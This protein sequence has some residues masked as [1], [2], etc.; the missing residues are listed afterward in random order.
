M[1]PVVAE[2]Q[3]IGQT[4]SD[5]V[6]SGSGQG[7]TFVATVTGNVTQIAVRPG[8]SVS[9]DTLRVYNGG[10]GACGAAISTQ[11]VNTT[12]AADDAAP[13]QTITLSTPFPVVAGNNYSFVFNSTR[14]RVSTTNTYLN[15]AHV[16]GF[17]GIA[18]AYD[19]AFQVT[20]VIP[21]PVAVPTLSEW[22]MILFGLALAGAASLLISRRRQAL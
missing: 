21:P 19:V 13:L 6:F 18:P 14:L 12:A 11:T 9:G 2:A 3:T 15:G 4:S 5:T 20:Q 17:T 7:Q 8:T 22:A 16:F 10:C 1:T